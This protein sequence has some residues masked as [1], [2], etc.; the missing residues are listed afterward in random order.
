[1]FRKLKIMYFF[2]GVI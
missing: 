2:K 1:M